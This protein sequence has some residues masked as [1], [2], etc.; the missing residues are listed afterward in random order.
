MGSGFSIADGLGFRG[1][2][3]PVT[4]IMGSG[5]YIVEGSWIRVVEV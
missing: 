1:L 4:Y 2:G 5:L 3:L